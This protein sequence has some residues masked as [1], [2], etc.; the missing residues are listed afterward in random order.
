MY[1][2]W[3]VSE[4]RSAN[5]CMYDFIPVKKKETLIEIIKKIANKITY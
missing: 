5:A 1:N 4:G 3:C 2:C